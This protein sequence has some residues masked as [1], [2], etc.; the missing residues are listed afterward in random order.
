[1]SDKMVSHT[2]RDSNLSL[3]ALS[4]NNR[5]NFPPFDHGISEGRNDG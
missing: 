2:Y 3:T 4:S 1:M 5:P